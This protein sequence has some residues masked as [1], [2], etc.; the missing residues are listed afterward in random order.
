[1]Q[2]PLN[3]GFTWLRTVK[4]IGMVILGQNKDMPTPIDALV[5]KPSPTHHLR[6]PLTSRYGVF[7]MVGG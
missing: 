2:A 4:N 1:M 6:H 3:T 7:L 5:Q